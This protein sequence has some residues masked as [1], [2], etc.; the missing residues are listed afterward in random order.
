MPTVGPTQEEIAA[1]AYE[2]F[3][4]SGSLDGHDMEHWL[5]AEA[6]LRAQKKT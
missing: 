4:E 3:L 2:L 5:R 1:R 6:E